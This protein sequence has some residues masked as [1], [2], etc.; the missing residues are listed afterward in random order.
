MFFASGLLW[1]RLAP[2]IGGC[3]AHG[4]AV[5]LRSRLRRRVRRTARTARALTV[6]AD[7]WPFRAAFKR[8]LPWRGRAR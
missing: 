4:D 2:A 6:F 5:G 3:A 1:G 7:L 8:E